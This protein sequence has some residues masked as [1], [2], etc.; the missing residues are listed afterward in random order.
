MGGGLLTAVHADL[1]PVLVTKSDDV[2]L[3]VVQ[4]E[5]KSYKIRVFNAYGPQEDDDFMKTNN[6]WQSLEAEVIVAKEENCMII[7]ELDANA[8]IGKENY[9]M[10]PNSVSKNGELLLDMVNRQGLNIAN[11]SSK[12]SGVITREKMTENKR[13][14]SIL[15]YFILCDGINDYLKEMKIDEKREYIL[16]HATKKKGTKELTT[17]DHNVLTCEFEIKYRQGIPK[18]RRQFLNF[19]SRL[20][21]QAFFKETNVSNSLSYCFKNTDFQES[22]KLFFKHLNKK[23]HKCFDLVR[24][25][26]GGSR[27]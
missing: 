17:S 26:T 5:F 7:I 3:I 4:I 14:K 9:H 18:V 8:K 16:R 27:W 12:C 6:F 20:G 13:E 19:K 11:L 24:I 10:D 2:E 15:D 23:L 1:N 25:K 22:S 21:Q